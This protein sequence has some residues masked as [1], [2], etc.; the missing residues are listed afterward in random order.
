M[1]YRLVWIAHGT[2]LNTH[3]VSL[4]VDYQMDKKKNLATYVVRFFLLSCSCDATIRNQTY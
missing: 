3:G 4:S 1:G 2:L